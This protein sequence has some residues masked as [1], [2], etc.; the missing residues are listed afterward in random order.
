[1]RLSSLP[2]ALANRLPVFHGRYNRKEV[3]RALHLG[4]SIDTFLCR[5]RRLVQ[6]ICIR[7]EQQ[8][9]NKFPELQCVF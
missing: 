9:K 2:H 4:L 7:D 5:L 6:A 1:M 8:L 3:K